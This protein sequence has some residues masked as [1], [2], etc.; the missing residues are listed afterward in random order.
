VFAARSNFQPGAFFNLFIT[1]DQVLFAQHREALFIGAQKAKKNRC[2]YKE[3]A[4]REPVLR[5]VISFQKK[6][7][8]V[9]R[10]AQHKLIG[11][12]A[13]CW[14]SLKALSARHQMIPR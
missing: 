9:A 5:R 8:Q 10:F 11:A 6:S 7:I 4:H 3:S 14:N 13:W 1:P 2:N 12:F